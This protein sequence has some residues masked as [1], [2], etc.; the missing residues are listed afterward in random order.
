MQVSAQAHPQ[1]PSTRPG[2]LTIGPCLGWRL[3]SGFCYC[4]GGTWSSCCSLAST[5]LTLSWRSCYQLF[6]LWVA[7]SDGGTRSGGLTWTSESPDD[8][9]ASS[10]L[11]AHP[12]H[13]P[14]KLRPQPLRSTP[15]A[16]SP[17]GLLGSTPLAPSSSGLLG[18]TPGLLGSTPLAS[19]A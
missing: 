2:C 16:P 6:G 3:R 8:A 15:L 1:N 12:C 9:A 4:L 11:H 10:S 5:F 19:Q 17:S 14:P 7:C 13:F 18:R